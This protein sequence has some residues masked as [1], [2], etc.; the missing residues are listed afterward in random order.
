MGNS[1]EVPF[2]YVVCFAKC[3]PHFFMWMQYSRVFCVLLYSLKKNLL[4]EVWLHIYIFFFLFLIYTFLVA[5]FFLV[6]GTRSAHT[7][8][9][10][11]EGSLA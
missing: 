6:C 3:E 10:K 2:T 8:S 4:L 1:H 11:P 5:D 9:K 7:C